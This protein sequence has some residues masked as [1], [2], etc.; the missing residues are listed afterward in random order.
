[1]GL[2]LLQVH[3]NDILSPNFSFVSEAIRP[4][5]HHVTNF[6]FVCEA[7]RPT[8][9]MDSWCLQCIHGIDFFNMKGLI[10]KETSF[11]CFYS[12]FLKILAK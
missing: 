9:I 3:I 1:V 10:L 2:I 7:I 8:C 11:L 5:S 4:T 12:S 6:S